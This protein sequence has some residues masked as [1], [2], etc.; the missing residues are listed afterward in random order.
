MNRTVNPLLKIEG[1]L[2]RKVE[3]KVAQMR[4]A[5]LTFY[6]TDRTVPVP[7]TSTWHCFP[8]PVLKNWWVWR[9]VCV[10]SAWSL[11]CLNWCV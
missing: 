11:L 1:C 4:V 5:V 9:W 8:P 2:S 6:G 7:I 10:G 3:S